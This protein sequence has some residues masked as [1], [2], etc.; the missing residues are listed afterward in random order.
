MVVVFFVA[1]WGLSG[2][3]QICDIL[4]SG[5]FIFVSVVG[6]VVGCFVEYLRC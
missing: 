5:C 4:L 1:F 6:V 2:L 3:V